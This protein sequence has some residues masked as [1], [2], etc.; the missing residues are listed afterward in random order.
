M[1]KQSGALEG[2][3][4]ADARAFRDRLTLAVTRLYASER[5]NVFEDT[6]ASTRRMAVVLAQ[7]CIT[8]RVKAENV[9]EAMAVIA[10]G[11]SL[12][13][14]IVAEGML[15]AIHSEDDPA[16]I[17]TAYNDLMRYVYDQDGPGLPMDTEP[18]AS[19]LRKAD[20]QQREKIIVHLLAYDAE[21]TFRSILAAQHGSLD[22]PASLSWFDR[23]LQESRW[24]ARHSI[25]LDPGFR[26][27]LQADFQA[28]LEHEVWWV[29]LYAVELIGDVPLRIDDPTLRGLIDDE[30]AYVKARVKARLNSRE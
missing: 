6:D 5:D 10:L 29:R 9:G 17:S 26:D 18:I 27:R 13:R 4:P 1:L 25:E 12:P 14:D 21:Q 15:L 3:E 20:D 30:N 19:W 23:R 22:N 16:A 8:G 7:A 2:V 11:V 28:L 24:S